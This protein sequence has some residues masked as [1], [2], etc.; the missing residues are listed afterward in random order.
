[1]QKKNTKSGETEKTENADGKLMGLLKK[2]G[3]LRK[4][5]KVKYERVQKKQRNFPL[6][7][8]SPVENP[9]WF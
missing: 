2:K 1:L 9:N 7:G 8:Q 6:N 5:E 3:A 4:S